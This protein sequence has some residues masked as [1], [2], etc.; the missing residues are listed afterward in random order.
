MIILIWERMET[1]VWI[2]SGSWWW[3]GMPGVLQH[4]GSHR[5]GHNWA[6]ELNW[7]QVKYVA[8]FLCSFIGFFAFIHKHLALSYFVNFALVIPSAWKHLPQKFTW[9]NPFILPGLCSNATQTFNN[10]S[11]PV[12]STDQ[13]C[14]T[15]CDPRDCSIPGLP[16]HH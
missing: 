1:W 9:L 2:S 4:M 5:V 13:S 14:L 11:I 10:N 12:S 8:Q 6:T 7:R 16:V 15:L 3:T